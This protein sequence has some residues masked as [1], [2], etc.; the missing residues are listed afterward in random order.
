MTPYTTV[1]SAPDADGRA[2][3]DEAIDRWQM[4]ADGHAFETATSVLQPVLWHAQPGVPGQKAMLKV[5]KLTP[6]GDEERAGFAVQQWWRGR[7]AAHVYAYSGQAIV[8]ERA[9]GRRSLATMSLRLSVADDDHA[10]RLLCQTVSR[11]HE[12]RESPPVGAVSLDH[13][14]GEL[15]ERADDLGGAYLRGAD[16]AAELLNEQGDTVLLHGDVHHN[17]VLDFDSRGWLAI[18]P[19]GL[20]GAREFDYVNMLC[21]PSRSRAAEPKRLARR[22]ATVALASGMDAQSLV[23]WTI[24]WTALSA[25]WFTTGEDH[26]EAADTIAI[27]D[28]ATRL[29]LDA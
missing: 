6:A 19:K 29:L 2:L 18:D 20:V 9:E 14:F 25:T 13:W 26:S 3:L 22:V 8:L 24:A 27:S 17:N 23:R 7:G 16:I 15:F 21:N 10:L 4:R 1:G 28:A 5:A 12:Q 11:L